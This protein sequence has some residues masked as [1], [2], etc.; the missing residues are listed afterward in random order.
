[1]K[2][3]ESTELFL[4]YQAGIM[5]I[6]IGCSAISRG[7]KLK[8]PA[9]QIFAKPVQNLTVKQ[10]GFL[11]TVGHKNK[12][13]CIIDTTSNLMTVSNIFL[14]SP[15]RLNVIFVE[16][17]WFM[18]IQIP[19]GHL[20]STCSY[21]KFSLLR[22]RLRCSCRLLILTGQQADVEWFRCLGPK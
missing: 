19:T 14:L 6:L 1:M 2:K 21:I 11:C 3:N 8:T 10:D 4:S 7:Q 13:K 12:Y 17:P 22:C 5:K 15:M 16:Y 20:Y 18:D 9:R